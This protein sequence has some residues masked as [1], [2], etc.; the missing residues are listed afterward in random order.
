MK[1]DLIW[2]D[3][4]I[5]AF[6][7]YTPNSLKGIVGKLSGYKLEDMQL[8][9]KLQAFNR[10]DYSGFVEQD[11]MAMFAGRPGD[12]ISYYYKGRAEWEKQKSAFRLRV[13]STLIWPQTTTSHPWP[14]GR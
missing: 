8:G 4:Y 11:R 3:N 5:G 9:G 1:D 6:Y 7:A 12:A 2:P 10:Y 14:C 13:W